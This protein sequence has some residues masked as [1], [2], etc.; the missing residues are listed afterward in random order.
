MAQCSFCKEETEIYD[1]GDV[2]VCVECLDARK[3]ERNPST[4]EQ[5]VYA[6]IAR[7]YEFFEATSRYREATG[8]ST[9]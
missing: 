6:Y 8:S 2:P 9:A 5:H 4:T 7:S 1:G 3:A